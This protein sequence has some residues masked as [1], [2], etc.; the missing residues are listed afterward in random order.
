M[1]WIGIK[2][3]GRTDET[4]LRQS[5]ILAQ[6]QLAIRSS[7]RPADRYQGSQPVTI[8]QTID[9]MVQADPT[10]AW[11]K[12][13]QQRGDVDWRQ[14]KELHDSYQVQPFH[15]WAG[16]HAGDHYFGLRAHCRCREWRRWR[17]RRGRCRIWLRNGGGRLRRDGAGGTAVGTATAGWAERHGHRSTDLCR[18]RQCYQFYQ[19]WRQP[20]RHLE[21]VTSSAALKGYATNALTAGFTA[22]VIDPAFGVT[23]DKVNGITQGLDLASASDIAKFAAYSGAQGATQAGL[24]TLL[25]GGGLKENLNQA[26]VSQLQSTLQAIAF[27]A[28]GTS[29][30]VKTGRVRP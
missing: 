26:L 14:V 13:A 4:M 1:A 17:G 24:S 8:G 5:E 16:S 12:A 7:G 21:D 10:L 30:K 2:G 25:Q 23:G 15:A 11:I 3:E 22:G 27:N 28:V 20:W 29:L 9:A 18:Q 19:Q 6:G